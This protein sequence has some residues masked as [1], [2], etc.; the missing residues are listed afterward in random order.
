MTLSVQ[1]ATYAALIESDPTVKVEKIRQLA[2]D[3]R[4]EK[5]SWQWVAA[6]RLEQPGRPE[7]PP[8]V[9]PRKVPRRSLKSA[10]GHQALIHAIA[11]IEFN[12]INLALDAL[13]RFAEMPRQ[14]YLDW[15]LV[16]EEEALHFS[17]LREHLQTLGADYGDFPAHNGLWQMALKTQDNVLERMALVPRVLEARGLDVTP[18]IIKKLEQIEDQRAVEILKIIQRDEI[19][20]VKIGNEWFLYACEQ[21]GVEP[22]QTFKTLLDQH[23]GGAL[24]GPFDE[25]ARLQ[26]GFTQAEL[27]ELNR[28]DQARLVVRK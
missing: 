27:D 2:L 5:L 25:V 28:L 14:F 1:R 18:G 23:M 21:E 9:E 16:A 8:L 15:L 12:A 19:G 3:L 20:H 13:Y 7:K 26:A 17:L 11:H 10:Q 22:M 4:A 6:E 24:R